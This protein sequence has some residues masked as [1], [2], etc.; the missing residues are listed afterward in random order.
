MPEMQDVRPPDLMGERGIDERPP[1]AEAKLAPPMLRPEVIDRPRILRG[2][3][4]GE[5]PA[6]T[7]VVAPA[8]YGK[9]IAVRAWGASRTRRSR[10]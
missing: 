4:S 9:T 3:D 7:L 6:L 10:G 1:L 5:Q 2:L 8:G